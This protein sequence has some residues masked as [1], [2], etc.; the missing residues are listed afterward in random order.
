MVLCLIEGCDGGGKTTLAAH[1][2]NAFN[3]VTI[4]HKGPPEPDSCPF[5]EY[6][7]TLDRQAALSSDHLVILDRWH[8]G[9]AFYGP[10]Y[11]GKSRLDEGGMAHVE[12]VL[13]GLGAAKILCQPS[14]EETQRR[15]ANRGESFLQPEDVA[16]VHKSYLEHADAYSY[17]HVSGYGSPEATIKSIKMWLHQSQASR[18]SG[19]TRGTYIGSLYPQAVLCGDE[20][21]NGPLG[22]P[23]LFYPFTPASKV[24]SGHYLFQAI[25]KSNLQTTVGVVNTASVDDFRKLWD[26]LGKP[27]L[28]ALGANAENRL[29]NIRLPSER[30]YHPQFARRFHYYDL[31]GYAQTIEKAARGFT[32]HSRGDRV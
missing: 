2:K 16:M 24:Y 19:L 5:V 21:K 27:R 18:V 1:L 23:E 9:E 10:L 29:K 28:V 8:V 30:V 6:E 7:T 3:Q 20:P 17:H 13:S 31:A 26:V 32:Q 25:L 4:I 14:L 22:R 12:M 11:R 15:L